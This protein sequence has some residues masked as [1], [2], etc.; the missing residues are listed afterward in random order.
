MK[1]VMFE[2]FIKTVVPLLGT[3]LMALFG[4][5]M[6]ALAAKWAAD[7]KNSKLAAVGAKLTMTVDA[8]V[9]EVEATVRQKY[10]EL[11][12]DGD[13][14]KEDALILK[15]TAINKA[16]DYLG[17]HGVEEAKGILGIGA[18][19]FVGL[20]GGLVEKAVAGMPSTLP[21]GAGKAAASLPL[22]NLPGGLPSP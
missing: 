22:P 3:L 16:M 19:S 13:L 12:A 4:W 18:D 17:K 15:Q 8:A 5:A 6:K 14:S 11:T 10:L 21:E 9:H 7:A 1:E 20:L 2:L